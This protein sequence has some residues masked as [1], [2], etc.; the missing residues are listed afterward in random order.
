MY[1]R[2]I[3]LLISFLLLLVLSPL[4]FLVAFLVFCQD[5]KHPLY[6]SS[7]VGLHGRAFTMF[8]MRSMVVNADA[9][10][11]DSTSSSDS[12]IT[13]LGSFIRRFK[14]D[15]LTQLINVFLGN[16]SLV[17]PRPNVQ[18]EVDLYT[19]LE[20]GLLSVKPGITD[21]SSI[22]F[23]DEGDIL[24]SYEDP[25]LAYNQLIRPYKSRL[26]LFYI[27]HASLSLDFDIL[28][29]T[30]LSI[31][32]RQRVLL[33]LSRLLSCLKAPDDLIS[34]SARSQPLKP[35]PPPG[36]SEIVSSR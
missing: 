8:K 9:S 34:V 25:D 21:I 3:D 16:M 17:G 12:R 27:A 15:E 13:P 4:L 22:V 1:K 30:F 31:F 6:M 2:L 11:V 5:F 18:R 28:L 29:L 32:D 26:G 10:G 7:R 24:S 14:I 23:S 35:A 19:D 20:F 36:A 33:R